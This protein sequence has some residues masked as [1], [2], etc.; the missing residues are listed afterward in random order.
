MAEHTIPSV[1]TSRRA[2]GASL[3]TWKGLRYRPRAVLRRL[4]RTL[5]LI[6]ALFGILPGGDMIVEQVVELA[7]HGHF[8]HTVPGEADPFA[9]EHGCS[10]AEQNCSCPHAQA[11]MASARA[12]AGAFPTA[13]WITWMVDSDRAG[14]RPASARRRPEQDRIPANRATAPPTPPANA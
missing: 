6:V 13:E 1:V 10:P 9:A 4:A 12:E 2:A 8:A 11:S 5:I 3:A 7:G 14:R